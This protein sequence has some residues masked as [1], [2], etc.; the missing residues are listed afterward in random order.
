MTKSKRSSRN[1]ARAALNNFCIVGVCLA[2]C[3]CFFSSGNP[4]YTTQ[5]IAKSLRDVALAEYK[6]DIS[7]KLVGST[8]WVYMPVTDLFI[9]NPKSEKY[10]EKFKI[11]KNNGA[12][13]DS[14]FVGEY[15]IK[16]VPVTDKAQE[17]KINKDISEKIG[18]L[19]KILRRV[20]FSI[21]PSQRDDIKFVVMVIADVKNGFEVKEIFYARDLKKV[22]YGLM[23]IW[24]FQHRVIQDSSVSPLVI[25]DKTGRHVEYKDLTLPDFIAQQIEY[26]ISLKFQKPE[27]EQSV[28][29]DK[30]V[31]KIITETLRMYELTEI[32]EIKFK[33]IHLNT[34]VTLAKPDIWGKPRK[35]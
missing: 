1:L 11:L 32:E 35:K 10:P 26:R 13:K 33:N 28:D 14:S 22:S 16:P 21:E 31:A 9:K 5:N 17:Y 2:L 18:T 8:L 12:F 30:E 34:N 3:G 27:V 25:G 19:W 4:T 7:V 29:I 6:T 24:E 20:M 15:L 23:S